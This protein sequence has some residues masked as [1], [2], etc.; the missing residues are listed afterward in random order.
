MLNLCLNFNESLP[1]LYILK[2]YLKKEFLS[3]LKQ[4]LIYLTF[5]PYCVYLNVSKNSNIDAFFELTTGA[6]SISLPHLL[7]LD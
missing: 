1:I 3:L 5:S 6:L 7:F 4:N 2:R